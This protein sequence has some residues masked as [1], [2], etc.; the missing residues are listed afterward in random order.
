MRQNGNAVMFSARTTTG[1]T[2]AHPMK[3]GKNTF[4]A[5]GETSS[6]SGAATIII[7]VSNKTSPST[8]T[9][10]DGLADWV[11]AGTITLT[12]GTTMTSDAFALDAPYMWVRARLSSISGTDAAVTVWKASEVS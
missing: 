9:S 8:A 1:A 12:L 4:L 11:T 5:Q 3:G 10:S 2:E 6:G 7:E